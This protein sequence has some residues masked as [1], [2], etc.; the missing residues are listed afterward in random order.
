LTNPMNMHALPQSMALVETDDGRWFA[1]FAPET[2][3]PDWI[4]LVQHAPTTIVPAAL[5]Q[6][7]DVCQGYGC[8]EEAIEAYRAWH[9][10]AVLPIAW[11]TLAASTE[12]YPERNAWYLEEIARLTGDSTP[13]LSCGI[14]V[15]AVVITDDRFGSNSFI[16]V[17][18]TTIDETVE[19]LYQRVY[20]WY[21][22]QQVLQACANGET[23][24]PSKQAQRCRI[25][26]SPSGPASISH[27]LVLEG[28]EH[29]QKSES[30]KAS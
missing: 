10:A 29:E 21:C 12:V 5:D 2:E 30:S 23:A 13:L 3:Q 6:R 28:N 14:D 19:A 22:Q 26:C 20:R 24:H 1:G 16:A 15:S 7:S 18:G 8:R 27:S 25:S 4:L 11:Q 9:E 17:A